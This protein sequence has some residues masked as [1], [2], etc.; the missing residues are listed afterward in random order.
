M[1]T[2]PVSSSSIEISFLEEER[3]TREEMQPFEEPEKEF[4]S[5]RRG[6]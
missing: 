1:T 5:N 6:V 2:S 3:R 4:A